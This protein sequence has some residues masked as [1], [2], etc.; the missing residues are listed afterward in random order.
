MPLIQ[1]TTKAAVRENTERELDA[2]KPPDQ[3]Y[4]IANAVRR[5]LSAKRGKRKV[6]LHAHG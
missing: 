3:A 2:G 5:R 4:A 1:S 6:N